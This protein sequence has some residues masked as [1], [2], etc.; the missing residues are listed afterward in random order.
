M[1]VHVATSF[2]PS[3]FMLGIVGL[4]VVAGVVLLIWLL[5]SPTGRR[6]ALILS[7]AGLGLLVVLSMLVSVR[8]TPTTI[9]SYTEIRPFNSPPRSQPIRVE[10]AKT[11]P[12]DDKTTPVK[13]A[14]LTDTPPPRHGG[15]SLAIS[16][17]LFATVAECQQDLED[18]I[19]PKIAVAIKRETGE[20]LSLPLTPGE[21]RPLIHERYVE[22][23]ST[24][25]GTWYK[26][27]ALVNIDSSALD[28]LQSTEDQE[29]LKNRLGLLASSLGGVMLVLGAVYL[30]LRRPPRAGET[31][32][33]SFTTT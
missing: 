11:L 3:Y 29:R 28:M 8:S 2:A 14:W 19:P 26:V 12:S 20:S 10:S 21:V 13:P 17:E 9:R 5:A 16:S 4:V 30:I 18:R 27:H 31:T 22:E 33:E 24:T 25:Q 6:A 15:L 32:P 23:I 1:N 7:G